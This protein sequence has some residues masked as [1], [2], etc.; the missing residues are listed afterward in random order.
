MMNAVIQSRVNRLQLI[1]AVLGMLGLAVCGLGF[2]LNRHQFFISY[3]TAYTFWLGLSLGCLG[4][5][6]IHHLTGG[7]WG[8]VTRRMLEAAF[9]ALPLMVILFLP[10]LLGLRELYPWARPE[11]VAAS[12]T[13]RQKAVYM[14]VPW[15]CVRAIFFFAVWLLMA[16]RLRE[17]S[18]QQDGTDDAAPTIRMRTLSGPGIVIY[19][20]TGTFAFVDWVMST[21][22]KWYSTMF[23]VIVLIGQ[24]LS[25][26]AFVTLL[27]AWFHD[28]PPFREVATRTHFHDLG[29]L[30][31]A[32]V[33][34]WTYVSFGQL[35]I[36]YSGNLP[37]EIDW[38][39]YRIAGGW[40]WVLGALALF[41]FFVPF[42]LLLFRVMK[43]NIARLA[44]IAALVF[45]MHIVEVYWVIEP[46][47]FRAGAHIHWLDFA[48][49]LGIGG[50]WLVVF[51]ANFKR[52]PLLPRHDP[53]IEYPASVFENAN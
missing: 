30:L 13:L 5:A 46:S 2:L 31:L 28:Q 9:M 12:D 18:H 27:L 3:L 45:G 6:M 43:Q 25:A 52:Q 39:L 14:N 53:R 10:L 41:H 21:E 11:A 40:K 20:L 19:P 26:F 17:W 1:G 49:V 35:L 36:I 32:F 16:S 23:L 34:F 15:F 51:T 33:I 24:I 48:A 47:F 8:F 42:F 38:Y 29:N 44:V 37:R 22:P 50:V 7:R 4:V